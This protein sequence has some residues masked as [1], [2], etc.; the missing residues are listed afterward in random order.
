MHPFDTNWGFGDINSS[1][2]L[3]KVNYGLEPFT[4]PFIRWISWPR[5][6]LM[7]IISEARAKGRR[8]DSLE[9][10]QGL[11]RQQSLHMEFKSLF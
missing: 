5:M 7:I 10:C 3:T 4:H 8:G 1:S 6:L 2:R 11:G 9:D